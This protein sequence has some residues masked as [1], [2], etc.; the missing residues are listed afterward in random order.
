MPVPA[1]MP[2]GPVSPWWPPFRAADSARQ[3]AL[4]RMLARINHPPPAVTDFGTAPFMLFVE[5]ARPTQRPHRLTALVRASSRFDREHLREMYH[6]LRQGPKLRSRKGFHIIGPDL[7][8]H[9]QRSTRHGSG[10]NRETGV[11][12]K[13][14]FPLRH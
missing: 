11:F 10:T 13:D 1:A 2:F 6:L 8:A 7:P 5:L 3:H 14:I 9:P 12:T 4:P